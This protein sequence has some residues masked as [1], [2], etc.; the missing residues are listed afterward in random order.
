MNPLL[1]EVKKL[2]QDASFSWAVC[3]GF[4]L[5]LFLDA[6]IRTHGDIDICVFERNRETILRHMLERDWEVY[7][8]R[9]M[10]KVRPIRDAQAS[11]PGR[12]VLCLKE[13]CE[14][15]RFYPC[16]EQD[17]Y[18]QFFHTGIRELN[19]VE[20][21]F[22]RAENGAFVFDLGKEIRKNLTEV[23]RFR[24]GIPYLAPEIALLY[25]AS[26]WEE[27]QNRLDFE[28]VYPCMEE[29]QQNWLMRSLETLYPQGHPWIL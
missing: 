13:G 26:R 2:L 1:Q 27:E 14:L 12:N 21:L 9:G 18:H 3:G 23:I 15:I 4:G 19:Y 22:N 28:R 29:N 6:E 16:D 5:E 17:Q 25:K 11:E 8:F 10:G 24:E 20:F 7:E